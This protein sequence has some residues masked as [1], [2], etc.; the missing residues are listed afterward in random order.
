MIDFLQKST[1]GWGHPLT[2]SGVLYHPR[3]YT[4][5]VYASITSARK[6]SRRLISLPFPPRPESG[7]SHVRDG[8][9]QGPQN[10]SL[11]CLIKVRNKFATETDPQNLGWFGTT[12]CPDTLP[13]MILSCS[14]GWHPPSKRFPTP[15]VKGARAF[16]SV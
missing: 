13:D 7:Y 14:R 12:L 15:Y 2:S 6:R 1:K 16:T 4:M 11:G 10:N 9:F 5:E 8:Y 3:P